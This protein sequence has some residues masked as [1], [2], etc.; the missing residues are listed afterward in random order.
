VATQSKAYV[1]CRLPAEIVGSNPTGGMDVCC[2]C[3]VLSGRGLWDELITRVE[4][5]YRLWCVVVY[6]IETSWRRRPWPTGGC[7][8][9]NK[10][11]SIHTPCATDTFFSRNK[12]LLQT[13]FITPTKCTMYIHYL[14][15]IHCTFSWCNYE[16][17]KVTGH[18]AGFIQHCSSLYSRLC[19]RPNE[20][21]P[22]FVS[23]G[24]TTPS[25]AGALY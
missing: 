23:R 5:S 8:D 11:I 7:C 19:S 21:V 10:Q 9:K 14:M 13:C 17:K 16:L 24:A 22:S 4:E 3:C 12:L 20:V 15:N 6:D 2:V 1:C 25:G 18:K